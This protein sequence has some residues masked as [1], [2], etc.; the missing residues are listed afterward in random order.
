MK[1]CSILEVL[2]DVNMYWAADRHL[3]P[4]P[5]TNPQQ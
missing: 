4:A 1:D 2:F 5:V 3:H